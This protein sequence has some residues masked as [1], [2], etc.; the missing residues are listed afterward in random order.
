MMPLLKMSM[1]PHQHALAVFPLGKKNKNWTKRDDLEHVRVKL[2]RNRTMLCNFK[3]H[4]NVIAREQT[5]SF[6]L[7]L[8][9]KASRVDVVR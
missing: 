2:W 6:D 3:H 1:R 9:L 5:K 4:I 7:L 8:T